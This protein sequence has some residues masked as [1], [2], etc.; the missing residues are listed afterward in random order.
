MQI[1]DYELISNIDKLFTSSIVILGM[2][3]RGKQIFNL[4]RENNIQIKYIYDKELEEKEYCGA[5]RVSLDDLNDFLSREECFVI[6][7]TERCQDELIN[8]LKTRNVSCDLYTWY[9]VQTA[10]ELNIL[11]DRF[12]PRFREEL[13]L[14]KKIFCH[15][16]ETAYWLNQFMFLS[17]CYSPIL[18]YQVGK[19]GSTS[20]RFTLDK[21]KIE[22]VHLHNLVENRGKY[23]GLCEEIIAITNEQ[24]HHFRTF[25]LSRQ[26]KIITLVRDPIGREL[27]QFMQGFYSEY[28]RHDINK[29]LL[30]YINEYLTTNLLLNEEFEW[31]NR[32][33]KEFTGVDI[34]SYPFDKEKG[35][36]IIKKNNFEILVLKMEQMNQNEKIIGEFVGIEDFKLINSNVGLEKY[37]RYIYQG[38]KKDFRISKDV[39]KKVYMENSCLDHFYTLEEKQSFIRKWNNNIEED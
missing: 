26:V 22:N 27:S 16:Y 35:Y 23:K 19:V 10:I 24:L 25:L 21:F 12:L 31:F 9:G 6:I 36:T 29:E 11:D 7:G 39:I 33:I 20:L 38:L 1:K 14:R 4:L 32:E 8:E 2:G 13:Q 30:E 15:N 3:Y 18:I 34:Y 17:R 37:Y 28:I 5:E